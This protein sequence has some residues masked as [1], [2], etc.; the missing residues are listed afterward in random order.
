ML[1]Y[2]VPG[3]TNTSNMMLDLECYDQVC[4]IVRCETTIIF[5]VHYAADLSNAFPYSTKHK[6]DA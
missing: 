3:K 2:S 5:V 4:M 1:I 6:V